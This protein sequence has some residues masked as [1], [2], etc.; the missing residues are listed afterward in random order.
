MKKLAIVFLLMI[1]FALFAQQNKSS[2]MGQVSLEELQMTIYDKDSTA[3]AVVLYEHGNL[4][5]DPDNEYQTRI[6]YYFKIKILDK[7]AFEKANISIDLYKKKRVLD[8]K[9]ITYNISEIKTIKPTSLSEDNIFIVEET[10]NWTSHKFTLPN[11]KVGSV[12]EYSYSIISPYLGMPDWYFQ[13][14][15][16]K[17]KSDYDAA[18]LGNYQYNIRIVGFLKLD[19]DKPSIDK[20]C[21][22]IDGVGQGACVIYAYAMYDIP[23]FKEED[24]M[25]SKKN[26]ISRLSFDLKTYTSTRGDIQNYTTTWKE[27]DKKLKKI[28]F[29]NQTSKKS[30]FKKRIPDSI[31]VLKDQQEKAKEIYRFIQN[32]YTWNDT[33]WN[34]EDEKVK[35]AFNNKTGS[36]GEINLSLYN[37][38]EA[39]EIEAELV[40]LSTRNHGLP[41]T[42]YPVI[43]DFNYLIIRILIDGKECYLDATDKYLPFGQVPVRTLN[44]KAR[45]INYKKESNWISLEPKIKSSKKITAK[46]VLSENG[47]FVGNLLI[48]R[49]GYIAQKQRKK[50]AILSE[51]DYLEEFEEDNP[52]IE[53]EDYRVRFQDKL[54]KSLQEVFKINVIMGNDLTRKTRINPFFFNRLKENP[55]KL[56]ERN[57]PVDFGYANKNSFALSIEIPDTYKITQLPKE[58]AISLPNNGGSFILKILNNGNNIQIYSRMNINK[59]SYSSKEYFALKEFFKQ[60]VI[61]ENSFLVLEKNN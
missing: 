54:D 36:A 39:F 14:D 5:L 25:L 32:H 35:D 8:I 15:I 49:Q 59:K 2:A 3:A 22:Y 58:V 28:F 40:I 12:I 7:T 33:Y 38:L 19:K 53:V 61:A 52:D 30:F 13:S 50:L 48:R 43:F 4:Y 29:N 10:E 60:I 1:S 21:L 9:A 27:A 57:Y 18:V 23:A 34:N 44:G 24:Y 55:F 11:I 20:N 26:Y 46:L 42:L 17:I 45:I 41:T 47:E 16:P 37:A 6:D 56:K 31:A 51:D